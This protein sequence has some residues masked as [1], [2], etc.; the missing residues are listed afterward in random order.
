VS[1]HSFVRPGQVAPDRPAPDACMQCA[2]PEAAHGP[3]VPTACP[4]WCNRDDEHQRGHPSH[5]RRIGRDGDTFVSLIQPSHHDQP[6]IFIG[7]D[8]NG[9]AA[10]V[11]VALA[12]ASDMSALLDRLGHPNIASLVNI[13]AER[14]AARPPAACGR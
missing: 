12:E 8:G 7:W 2:G 13:A 11:F 1:G 10:S 5:G 6:V 4:P 9:E 14:A 3:G